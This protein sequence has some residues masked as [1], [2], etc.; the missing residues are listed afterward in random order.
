M[1]LF[2]SDAEIFAAGTHTFTDTNYRFVDVRDVAR[3][4]I[5]AFESPSTNGRYCLVHKVV[6]SDD[7]F[8]ILWELYPALHLAVKYQMRKPEVWASASLLW[9]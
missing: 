1:K 7:A 9:R 8:K 2:P 5:E 6:H 3:A 4:C